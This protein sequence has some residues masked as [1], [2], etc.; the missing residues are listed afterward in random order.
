MDGVWTG[1]GAAASVDWC[2]PNYVVTPWVAEWWNTVSSVPIAGLGAFGLWRWSRS[3]PGREARFALGYA[4]LAIV[5]LGSIAFHGTL[6][7]AAQAC[8][9][10]PM[11]FCGLSYAYVLARR[12]LLPGAAPV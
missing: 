1:L 10:L 4:L 7:K 6:L 8:D 3:G 11:I 9:E 5:G 12:H 2:E